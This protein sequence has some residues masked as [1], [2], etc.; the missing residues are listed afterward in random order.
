MTTP[1]RPD[2]S[3][4][5]KRVALLLALFA[6]LVL[7]LSSCGPSS[8][9]QARQ[10]LTAADRVEVT[11]LESFGE[12]DRAHQAELRATTTTAAELE[13]AVASYRPKRDA[14]A[15]S[16]NALANASHGARGSL[17]ALEAA[18]AKQVD[19]DGRAHV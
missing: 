11:A 17:D 5:L 4:D 14:V 16:L 2:R 15:S 9:T 18:G 8:L 12:W 10:I 6:A 7:L 3:R 13:A 19:L 1:R